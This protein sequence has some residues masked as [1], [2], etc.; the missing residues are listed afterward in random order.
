MTESG[1][2]SGGGSVR[3]TATQSSKSNAGKIGVES[4]LIATWMIIV[5]NF[6]R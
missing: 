3:T 6:L 5:G 1:L 2:Q 4:G